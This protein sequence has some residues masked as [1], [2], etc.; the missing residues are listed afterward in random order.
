MRI[1]REKHRQCP[2]WNSSLVLWAIPCGSLEYHTM[3]SPFL[4]SEGAT[5]G[6]AD[7]RASY[8]GPPSIYRQLLYDG[9]I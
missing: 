9:L 8:A 7:G 2:P 5:T 3:D 4:V 6:S 1:G